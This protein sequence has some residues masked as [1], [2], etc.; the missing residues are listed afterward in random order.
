MYLSINDQSDDFK[1]SSK[2]PGFVNI[3][4]DHAKTIITLTD[5]DALRLE[6]MLR[7]NRI[8]REAKAAAA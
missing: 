3:M 2:A 5:S 4:T 6:N 7:V 1:V 8:V